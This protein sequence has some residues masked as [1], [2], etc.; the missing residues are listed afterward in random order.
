M[1]PENTCSI[2][3][4]PVYIAGGEVEEGEGPQEHEGGGRGQVVH[5]HQRQA[6]GEVTVPGSHETEPRRGGIGLTAG[7]GTDLTKRVAQILIARVA[8]RNVLEPPEV[9]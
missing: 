8:R 2:Y 7:A 3:V 4:V 5:R 1:V 9:F 6:L